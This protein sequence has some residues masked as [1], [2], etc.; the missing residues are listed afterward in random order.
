[1]VTQ[2]KFAKPSVKHRQPVGYNESPL[3]THTEIRHLLEVGELE[4]M[5]LEKEERPIV[6][7]VQR[8]SRLNR[9]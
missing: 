8:F 2:K 3:P 5:F 1:M 7:G 4:V 9:I 6:T